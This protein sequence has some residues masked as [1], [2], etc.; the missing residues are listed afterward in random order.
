MLKDCGGG[1]GEGVQI[2][3]IFLTGCILSWERDEPKGDSHFSVEDFPPLANSRDAFSLISRATELSSPLF[4]LPRRA[5][6]THLTLRLY[7]VKL[8][9]EERMILDRDIVRAKVFPRYWKKNFRLVV[10]G[11]LFQDFR[12]W[13]TKLVKWYLSALRSRRRGGGSLPEFYRFHPLR[14]VQ[15]G[16]SDPSRRWFKI[17]LLFS[18]LLPFFL[19][20]GNR[21]T[22]VET[23]E[24]KERAISVR[25]SWRE[26]RIWKYEN[27]FSW[28][29]YLNFFLPFKN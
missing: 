12:Y 10:Q 11:N 29:F 8:E 24:K 27:M 22:C 1:G 7:F 13:V 5:G 14:R 2:S 19:L 9:L 20:L 28:K 6:V 3:Q 15:F 25:V 4:F 18:T 17:F 16:W 26:K 23:N 21:V